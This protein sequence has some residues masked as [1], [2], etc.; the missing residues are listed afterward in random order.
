MKQ[1]NFQ[2]CTLSYLRSYSDLIPCQRGEYPCSNDAP[3]INDG[4]G[5]YMC[6]C[7]A[8]WTGTHC[9][10][11]INECDP[12]PCHSGSSCVVSDPVRALLYIVP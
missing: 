5:G 3:C 11:E 6:H 7:P 9:G 12:N 8:G 2:I 1:N 4:V 10:E